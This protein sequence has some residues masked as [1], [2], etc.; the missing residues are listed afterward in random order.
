MKKQFFSILVSPINSINDAIE[1]GNYSSVY[2]HISLTTAPLVEVTGEKR[3]YFVPISKNVTTGGEELYLNKF[4]L[5]LCK[6]AP[7]YLLGA[8]TV[9]PENKI[10]AELKGKSFV[11][12]ESVSSSGFVDR[13]IDRCCLCV[14]RGGDERRLDIV[15]VFGNWDAGNDWMFLAE[16]L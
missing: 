9:L 10:P 12:A 13:S 5:T 1:K 3:I 8:T 11:A 4:G 7:N 2:E 14:D 16:K 6:N 15:R